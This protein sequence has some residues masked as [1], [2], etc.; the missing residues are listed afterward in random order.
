MTE[1]TKRKI[2]EAKK[3]K[4]LSEEHKQK[5]SNALKGKTFSEER[6]KKVSEALKGHTVSDE[7]KK[8]L[9]EAAKNRPPISDETRKKL[10]QPGEKNGMYGYKWSEDQRKHMSDVLSG[11]KLTEE[12]RKKWSEVKMGHIVSEETKKKLSEINKGKKHRPHTEEEKLA[13]SIKMK[14]IL[15][16]KPIWNKGKSLSEEQKEKISA[17]LKGRPSPNK[18]KK[19]P[20]EVTI[21]I[22]ETKRQR[23]TFNSSSEENIAFEL[24]KNNYKEEDIVRGYSKDPRYPFQCDFYIVS[25]DKFIECNFHWTH[26]FRPY[27]SEDSN[28]KQQLLEWQENSKLSKYYENA[29]Y[30]WTDLDVRKLNLATINNLN[31]KVYYSLSEFK[32]DYGKERS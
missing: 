8:K 27:L 6:N 7:T 17:S 10:S 30:C 4:K 25:E 9:S 5:I 32:E 24:L 2:S 13:Q 20:E 28:C 14:E 11:R 29:I 19:R 22:N 12:Q 16:V 15:K 23:G 18:G 21:K 1:E 26:G 3:G 31:Y